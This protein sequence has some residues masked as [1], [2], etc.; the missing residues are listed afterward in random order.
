L[1]AVVVRNSWV[2]TLPIGISSLSSVAVPA[3]VV[4]TLNLALSPEGVLIWNATILLANVRVDSVPGVALRVILRIVGVDLAD[5][6][7][8]EGALAPTGLNVAIL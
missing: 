5:I 6:V 1:L 3:I 2:H 7:T 8:A 4:A